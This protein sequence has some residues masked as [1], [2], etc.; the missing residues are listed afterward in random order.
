MF[1]MGQMRRCAVMRY[2]AGAGIGTGTGAARQ[3][4]PIVDES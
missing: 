3:L 4:D 1:E 2:V